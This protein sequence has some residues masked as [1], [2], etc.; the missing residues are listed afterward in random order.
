MFII[1]TG[2]EVETT[3]M[4][5]NNGWI[6]SIW[7]IYTMVIKRNK[8]LKHD[9]TWMKILGWPKNSFGFFHKLLWA[10]LNKVFG[11]PS[12]ILNKSYLSQKTTYCVAPFIRN[13]QRRQIHRE[14]SRSV[15]A[16]AGSRAEWVVTANRSGVSFWGDENILKLDKS[17]G[18]TAL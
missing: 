14:E 5:I 7:Y 12:V 8:V 3:L 1:Y 11:Q 13:V 6:N 2:Q 15:V 4:S 9:K 10:N 16:G 17:H 18:C